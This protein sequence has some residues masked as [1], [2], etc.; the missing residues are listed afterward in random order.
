[1]AAAWQGGG[2]VGSQFEVL[3]TNSSSAEQ[4]VCFAT[5]AEAEQDSA[6]R[7]VVFV[8]PLVPSQEPEKADRGSG[9]VH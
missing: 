2:Q 3:M 8:V 9:H 4:R 6:V 5:E 7:H 1:M